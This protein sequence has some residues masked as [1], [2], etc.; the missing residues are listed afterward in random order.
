MLP[1]QLGWIVRLLADEAYIAYNPLLYTSV[2][3]SVSVLADGAR[4]MYP[5]AQSK[6]HKILKALKSGM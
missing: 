2:Y 6:K 1:E 4:N 3:N 5:H